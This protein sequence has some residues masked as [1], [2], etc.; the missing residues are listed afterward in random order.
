K[1]SSFDKNKKYPVLQIQYSGPDSQSAL[2]EFDFDWEYYLAE[3]GYIVVCVDGRG[4][5][6]RGEAFRKST[7]CN[8]GIQETEDQIATAN[9]LK[10]QTYVDGSRIGIWGWSYGG[11]ITLMSMT[12]PSAVFKAGIAVGAV[13]DWRYYDSVYGERY[14]RTPKENQSGY[15]AGSPLLRAAGL[16]GRLLLVHGMLDDNVRVNQSLDMSEALIQSGIQFDM[17]LY[18]TSNHSILG[19]TYRKHLYNRMADFIFKNL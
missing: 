10:K 13:C 17:Q 9:F 14:M 4:T 18:P 12:D 5:G 6:G 19:E 8:L 1:P 7:W 11:Y 2:N 16:K 15:D 3:K